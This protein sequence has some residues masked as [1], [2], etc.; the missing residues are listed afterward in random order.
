MIMKYLTLLSIL[1][2]VSATKITNTFVRRISD[3]MEQG[4]N[5]VIFAN[6]I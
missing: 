5:L 1:S 3:L 6:D 4:S 2:V